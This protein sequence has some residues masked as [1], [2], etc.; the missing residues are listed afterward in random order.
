[1]EVSGC[2]LKLSGRSVERQR[3]ITVTDNFAGMAKLIIPEGVITYNTCLLRVM[4]DCQL[5]NNSF[6][7][8]FT[9]WPVKT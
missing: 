5:K 6:S 9:I 1:M 2:S 8:F 4:R 7:A 3:G